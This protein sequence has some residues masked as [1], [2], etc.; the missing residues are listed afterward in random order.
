[1]QRK[2]EQSINLNGVNLDLTSRATKICAIAGLR[3]PAV[4]I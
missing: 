4:P 3:A 2:P 1:M